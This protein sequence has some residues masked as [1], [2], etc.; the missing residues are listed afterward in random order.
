MLAIYATGLGQGTPAVPTGQLAP[1]SPLSSLGAGISVTIGGVAAPA[2]SPTPVLAPGFIGVAQLNV[3]VPAGVP[4]GTAQ[5]VISARGQ[6]SNS[7]A[8]MVQ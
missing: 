8:I 7:F 4:A 3:T 2:V 5:L 6:S 1:S